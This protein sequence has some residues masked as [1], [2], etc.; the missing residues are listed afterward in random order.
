M[1]QKRLLYHHFQCLYAWRGQQFC[2]LP[3]DK[4]QEVLQWHQATWRWQQ[5]C[6]LPSGKQQEVLQ[7]QQ[8]TQQQQQLPQYYHQYKKQQRVY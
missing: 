5:F 8:A 4:R 7:W 1:Y 2:S 3:Y 6:S